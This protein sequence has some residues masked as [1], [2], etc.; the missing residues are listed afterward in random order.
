MSSL[1]CDWRSSG[2]AGSFFSLKAEFLEGVSG[3][4]KTAEHYTACESTK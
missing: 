1:S 4:R 3:G 2:M